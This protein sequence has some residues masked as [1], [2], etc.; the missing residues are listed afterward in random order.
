MKK[1]SHMAPALL[2]SFGTTLAG[3]KL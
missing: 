2:L 3:L 1:Y